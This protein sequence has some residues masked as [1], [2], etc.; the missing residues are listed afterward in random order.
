MVSASNHER[1]HAGNKKNATGPAPVAFAMLV[2]VSAQPAR[3]SPRM[4]PRATD[5]AAIGIDT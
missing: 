2:R 5:A 4:Q 1:E 3:P